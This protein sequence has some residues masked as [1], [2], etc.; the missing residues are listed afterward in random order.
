VTDAEK[1]EWC[2]KRGYPHA[3]FLPRSLYKEAERQGYDMRYFVI[4][5][6]LPVT[7]GKQVPKKK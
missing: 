6:L 3:V 5:K 7:T 1:H 2:R 4:Q